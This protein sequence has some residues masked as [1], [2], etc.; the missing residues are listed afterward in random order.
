MVDI[1]WSSST[2]FRLRSIDIR[3]SFFE[4]VVLRIAFQPLLLKQTFKHLSKACCFR[5]R[6]NN[7]KKPPGQLA[8]LRRAISTCSP[9]KGSCVQ[10]WKGLPTYRT[11]VGKSD[12]CKCLGDQGLLYINMY[13]TYIF[14]YYILYIYIASSR[15]VEKKIY[16]YIY[17]RFLVFLLGV[18]LNV[19]IFFGNLLVL[20]A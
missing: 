18:V 14:I 11:S 6:G 8:R 16:I 9:W 5:C 19:T 20:G 3:L 2:S 4:D 13:I 10:C 15:Q 17:R 12:H 7:A 1:P